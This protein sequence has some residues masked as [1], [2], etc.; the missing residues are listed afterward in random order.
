MFEKKNHKRGGI[1]FSTCSLSWAIKMRNALFV[2]NYSCEI[3]H[4]IRKI[5]KWLKIKIPL[6][7]KQTNKQ[8]TVKCVG[9]Q[10]K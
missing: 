7:N 8:Q 1:N 10:D 3:R 6:K 4:N 9:S 5:Q 2:Q